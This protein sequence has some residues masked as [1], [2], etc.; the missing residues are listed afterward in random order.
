MAIAA[1]GQFRVGIWGRAALER[2]DVPGLAGARA[3]RCGAATARLLRSARNRSGDGGRSYLS[4][5]R[6][7][8]GDDVFCELAQHL[9]KAEMA[10]NGLSRLFADYH[11]CAGVTHQWL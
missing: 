8:P 11:A 6:P 1:A 4:N 5:L 2:P 9:C 7:T 10:L 3:A